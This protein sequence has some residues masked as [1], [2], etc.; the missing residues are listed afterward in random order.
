[1]QKETV[2]EITVDKE[3]KGI[4]YAHYS[5]CGNEKEQCRDTRIQR[6]GL[7]NQ[8]DTVGIAGQTGR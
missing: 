1:M 3:K 2:I 7:Y 4:G 5:I 6:Q 8:N